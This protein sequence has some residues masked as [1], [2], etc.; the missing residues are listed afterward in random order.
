MGAPKEWAEA[1]AENAK[2]SM[3]TILALEGVMIAETIFGTKG[4][5]VP[6][7]IEDQEETLKKA[8]EAGVKLVES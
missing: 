2:N 5:L 6:R 4:D 3:E 1:V 7:T 8:Y